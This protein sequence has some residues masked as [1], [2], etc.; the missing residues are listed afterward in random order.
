MLDAQVK[1]LKEENP[2]FASLIGNQLG[3]SG[4]RSNPGVGHQ[5]V[6]SILFCIILFSSRQG[7]FF[8]STTFQCLSRFLIVFFENY[9]GCSNRGYVNRK[10]VANPVA[11][12]E[13]GCCV[14]VKEGPKAL[15]RVAHVGLG[16]G[17]GECE[18]C[19]QHGQEAGKEA[20][21]RQEASQRQNAIASQVAKH[22]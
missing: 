12:S 16:L 6:R 9:F 7:S 11:F 15:F 5:S 4:P 3:G 10:C 21:P 20:A 8:S 22:Y 19:T 18:P 13:A 17:F 1:Q 2:Q 14:V